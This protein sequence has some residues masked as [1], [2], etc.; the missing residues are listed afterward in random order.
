MYAAYLQRK[1]DVRA[2]VL[3]SGAAGSGAHGRDEVKFLLPLPGVYASLHQLAASGDV[4]RL[5]AVLDAHAVCDEHHVSVH[6]A[7]G[8][9]TR[10]GAAS[11]QGKSGEPEARTVRGIEAVAVAAIQRDLPDVN[12]Y[13]SV[14]MTPLM[15]ACRSGHHSCVELLLRHGANANLAAS[16]SSAVPTSNTANSAADGSK[17]ADDAGPRASP[18]KQ[19][20]RNKSTWSGSAADAAAVRATSTCA[21]NGHTALHFAAACMGHDAAEQLQ[22]IVA[23]LLAQGANVAA[24]DAAGNTPLHTYVCTLAQQA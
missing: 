10:A 3:K 6:G 9:A 11:G 8:R 13:D 21:G 14:G 12:G 5:R 17:H 16:P 7:A 15:H 1:H 23:A 4:Q 20:Q 2:D 19:S 18:V 24:E 22:A